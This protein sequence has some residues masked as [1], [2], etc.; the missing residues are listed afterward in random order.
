LLHLFLGGC[1]DC[2]VRDIVFGDVHVFPAMPGAY[3]EKTQACWRI[4]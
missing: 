1:I 4:R 3:D 2:A